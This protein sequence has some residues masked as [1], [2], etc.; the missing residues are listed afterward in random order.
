MKEKD[1]A[2]NFPLGVN[3]W[4]FLDVDCTDPDEE[5]GNFCCDDGTCIDSELVCNGFSNCDNGTDESNC[6]FMNLPSR[7]IDT[8]KPSIQPI[9][10]DATFDVVEVFGINEVDST[11]DVHFILE[12]QWFDPF[13]SFEF[14]KS[15]DYDNYL[16]KT[17][18]E[19]IWIPRIEFSEIY[20]IIS[21]SRDR[22]DNVI[23]LRRGKPRLDAHLD[24]IRANDVFA[25]VENP[26]KI[27]IER[28]IKFS[29]SFDNIK[30][31]PFGTQK[32]SILFQLEGAANHMNTMV[33]KKATMVGQYV[34]DT[35][36]VTV[37][38]NV[39]TGRNM[40]RLTMVMS[41]KL[42]SIFMETYFP[43]ILMNMINQATN[44][45]TADTK[46]DMIITVN[47]TCM[48]VLASIY[49]SV[50]ASLPVTSDIKPVAV[51]L[52]FNLSY[53]FITILVNVLLQVELSFHFNNYFIKKSFYQDLEKKRRSQQRTKNRNIN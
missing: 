9:V 40:T 19:K 49:L 15:N 14:L 22:K 24:H 5:S 37:E 11:F 52:I 30:N 16:L 26:L 48:M 7:M 36:T 33:K 53:P 46:Y 6:T 50:S 47:I 38:F 10:L 28:R 2:S 44:Y 25:G 20:K 17:D 13:L 41:R 34:I 39:K 12:I 8:E 4:Q 21:S 45:I 29:C 32:C 1:K 27:L 23:V 18:R 42:G 3:Q 43:T 35:W 51:W 31:F